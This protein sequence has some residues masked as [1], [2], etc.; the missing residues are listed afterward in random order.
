MEGLQ[1]MRDSESAGERFKFREFITP[2]A[3]AFID[4][5]NAKKKAD[6]LAAS[7]NN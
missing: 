4:D 7:A 2:E 3:Q 1:E 5:M 6:K